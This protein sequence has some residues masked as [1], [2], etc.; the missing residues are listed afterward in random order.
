MTALAR[1]E[2]VLVEARVGSEFGNGRVR[3][4]RLLEVLVYK[5]FEIVVVKDRFVIGWLISRRRR[6]QLRLL[7]RQ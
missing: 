3:W 5:L 7:A 2:V 6:R 4:R 1:L